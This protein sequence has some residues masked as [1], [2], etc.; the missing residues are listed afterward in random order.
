MP[1]PVE[2]KEIMGH[3]KD[4]EQ[5]IKTLYGAP[6]VRSCDTPRRGAGNSIVSPQNTSWTAKS[7]QG[8]GQQQE[9]LTSTQLE[10]EGEFSQE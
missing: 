2:W 4:Q 1:I 9:H 3:Q 5:V 10:G 7:N 6:I 8:A